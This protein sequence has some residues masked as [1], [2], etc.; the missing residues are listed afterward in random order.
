MKTEN[1]DKLLL[2][3]QVRADKLK[4]PPNGKVNVIIRSC[5]ERTDAQGK[6]I[7]FLVVRDYMGEYQ[8]VRGL[9]PVQYWASEQVVA[10]CE[11]VIFY[12]MLKGAGCEAEI[13]DQRE[14]DVIMGIL[15]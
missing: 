15:K 8:R 2:E 6:I 13:A 1:L 9:Y 11:A 5:A 3:L 12:Y 14:L 10:L 7:A 4:L